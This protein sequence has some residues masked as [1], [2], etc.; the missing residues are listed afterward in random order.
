M[1][2]RMHVRSMKGGKARLS[3]ETEGSTFEFPIPTAWASDANSAAAPEPLRDKD[4]SEVALPVRVR[5]YE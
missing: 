2:V 1:W 5:V 3:K 4:E